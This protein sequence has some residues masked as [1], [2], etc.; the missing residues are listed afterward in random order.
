MKQNKKIKI[1]GHRGAK[2]YKP[3]NT[4]SSF[5]KAMELEADMIEFDVRALPTGEVVVIHDFVLNR[6]TNG[7]GRLSGV[8]FDYLR[9]LDAG[10]GQ[11]VP[12]L[13]EALDFIGQ[14]RPVYIEL[15]GSDIA[16]RVAAIIEAYLHKGWRTENLLVAS[17]NLDELRVFQKAMPQVKILG[18]YYRGIGKYFG[19]SGQTQPIRLWR[20]FNTAA[21]VK[22]AKEKNSE[23][24]IG[25]SNRQRQIRKL[26]GMGV[27][28]IV[29]NYPDRVVKAL[30]STRV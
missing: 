28:A 18:L 9:Q 12:T 8:S 29:T 27:D 20:R 13:Q 4:L 7:A 15:K 10:G 6:T 14:K 16:S 22:M 25:T 30:S 23:F 19:I 26:A 11:K 17:F 5:K 1:I 24:I 2:G 3:E 21:L